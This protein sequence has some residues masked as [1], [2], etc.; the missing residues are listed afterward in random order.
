LIALGETVVTPGTALTAA[1]I[2]VA[3]LASGSLAL[4]GTLCLWWLYFRAE[5][6]ALG[7]VASTGDRVY[8]S[9]MG[10]NG[11]LFM[12]AGLIALAAGNALVNDHP[13]RETTLALALMLFGGPAVFLAARLWYQWLVFGTASRTQLATIGLL[14]ATTAVARTAPA[15]ALVAA[16]AVVVLLAGLVV[17]EQPREHLSPIV[18]K[19]R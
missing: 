13:S 8:A 6:L 1:P 18:R 16:L 9:R 19:P 7:H 5:P 4:A 12:I 3:T 15:P 14:A 11:L 17:L 10:V 2:R